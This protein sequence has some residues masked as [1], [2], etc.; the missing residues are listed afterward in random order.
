MS[1][2]LTLCVLIERRERPIE[3]AHKVLTSKN[4][5]IN[6]INTTASKSTETVGSHSLFTSEYGMD[7]LSSQSHPANPFVE[8]GL[9][10]LSVP[11]PEQSLSPPQSEVASLM[12]PLVWFPIITSV[13][14]WSL[15]RG[16]F[17]TSPI[18]TNQQLNFWHQDKQI[19][20]IFHNLSLAANNLQL[21]NPAVHIYVLME[22]DCD[23]WWN[24]K[25][26]MLMY[27][28]ATN[29]GLLMS[30]GFKGIYIF[31]TLATVRTQ[32]IFIQEQ[33][34][35]KFSLQRALGQNRHK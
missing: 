2:S 30:D 1:V 12:A 13:Q 3:K 34:E 31:K 22:N 29:W 10:F 5:Y 15:N 28:T 33:Q 6:N 25:S 14:K 21:T 24:Y 35:R 11:W 26:C 20:V 4:N 19:T 18:I 23:K 17:Y 8:N 9:K 27:N 16:M 7:L 32:I